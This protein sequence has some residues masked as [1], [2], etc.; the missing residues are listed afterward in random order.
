MECRE[1][2]DGLGTVA[3]VALMYGDTARLGTRLKER[4]EPGSIELYRRGVQANRQH[5]RDRILARYPDA[6]L[7]LVAT[8]RALRAEI[9]MPDTTDGRAAWELVRR[10]VLPGLCL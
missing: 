1:N 3:G 8:P 6:G 5:Q 7:R 9:A 10:G 4:F 2:Q